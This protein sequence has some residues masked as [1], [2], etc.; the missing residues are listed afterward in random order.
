L[1]NLIL[2]INDL[3]IYDNFNYTLISSVNY[4]YGDTT[5]TFDIP[6]DT[7]LVRV[8]FWIAGDVD[9]QYCY[10]NFDRRISRFIQ[11]AEHTDFTSGSGIAR[12]VRMTVD[13]NWTTMKVTIVSNT[14]PNSNW[15]IGIQYYK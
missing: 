12:N 11:I 2:S 3:S 4:K 14:L 1:D 8:R 7:L 5:N 9:P 6:N 13:V 15:I 10:L